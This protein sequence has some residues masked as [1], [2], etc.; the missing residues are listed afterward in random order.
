MTTLTVLYERLGGEQVFH[1]IVA[2][3]Y[4]R[5]L[6]D[7]SLSPFF[8]GVD[9]TTLHAHQAAFLIQALG[10]PSEY[11]GRD[12]KTAHSGHRIEKK[13]FFAV[14]DHLVNA[15]SSIGVDEDLIGEVVDRLEPLS[16]EI[17]NHPA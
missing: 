3:F 2:E 8:D 17:V 5:M 10:G 12:L 14:A 15:M 13:H 7:P 11:H 6:A 4:R 16:H 1:D 9:M